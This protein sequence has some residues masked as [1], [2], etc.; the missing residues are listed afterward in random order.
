MASK[1]QKFFK[2]AALDAEAADLRRQIAEK[3]AQIA[4]REAERAAFAEK[5]KADPF[6]TLDAL[7]ITALAEKFHPQTTFTGKPK[8]WLDIVFGLSEKSHPAVTRT[9]IQPLMGAGLPKKTF[10]VITDNY[11]F[12]QL[13]IEDLAE[14]GYQGLVIMDHVIYPVRLYTEETEQE[15]AHKNEIKLAQMAAHVAAVSFGMQTIKCNVLFFGQCG[16]S[17]RMASVTHDVSHI[18][19]AFPDQATIAEVA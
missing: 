7:L 6:N 11:H 4:E 1:A 5:V 19:Q 15:W 13:T 16:F 2:Q 12:L 3:E 18:E 10:Q 14:D 17:H 9:L 8:K